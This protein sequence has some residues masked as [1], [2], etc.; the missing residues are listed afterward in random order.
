VL[1]QV[2][3]LAIIKCSRPQVTKNS[4]SMKVGVSPLYMNKK[5]CGGLKAL[6]REFAQV[7]T[8]DKL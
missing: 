4:V 1:Q 5:E 6:P 3:K 8:I 7:N 2:L